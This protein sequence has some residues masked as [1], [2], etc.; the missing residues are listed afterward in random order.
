MKFNV[1]GLQRGD[2]NARYASYKTAADINTVL[3][4]PLLSVQEM[5]DLEDL[6]PAMDTGLRNGGQ[7]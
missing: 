1:N 6:G 7:G 3:G 4:M 5:R 2:M